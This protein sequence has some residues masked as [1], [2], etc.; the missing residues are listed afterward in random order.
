MKK[1]IL[2]VSVSQE[3]CRRIEKI[4]ERFGMSRTSL[5][6]ILS[7]E[8]SHVRPDAFFQAIAAIPNELKTRPVGRPAG[9]SNKQEN[10]SAA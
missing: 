9:S 2:T 3:A 5:V 8:V 4:A 10:Q 1:E 6:S 7:E